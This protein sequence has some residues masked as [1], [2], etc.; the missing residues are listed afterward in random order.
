MNVNNLLGT[1]SPEALLKMFRV[2]LRPG[3]HTTLTQQALAAL[4]ERDPRT[5]RQWESGV[6]LP[7]AGSL[8]RLILAFLEERIFL[9]EQEKAEAKL[10][11]EAVRRAHQARYHAAYPP[12]DEQWFAS[13][14]SN[15]QQPATGVPSYEQKADD[16][17]FS[18]CLADWGEA[19]E[20]QTL[21]GREQELAL[22]KQ[23]VVTEHCRLV[24][25]AGMGGVG[26]SAIAVALAHQV[27]Q[28]FDFVLWRSLR[29]APAL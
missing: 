21:Y 17:S 24:M 16:Q 22:L 28:H 2:R 13:L 11:W 26:K 12:F 20:A 18:P 19:L 25:L 27:Q 7:S 15:R 3:T 23:W 9:E 29:N 4:L 1:R 6:R 5:I 14:M 10:L 8:Q